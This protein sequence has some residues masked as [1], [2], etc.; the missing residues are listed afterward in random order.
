MKVSRFK[1]DIF[2]WENSFY[3][4]QNF[5]IMYSG[6]LA[7]HTIPSHP[8]HLSPAIDICSTVLSLCQYLWILCIKFYN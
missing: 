5:F 3:F 7:F 6:K 1:A 4:L 2:F 8:E